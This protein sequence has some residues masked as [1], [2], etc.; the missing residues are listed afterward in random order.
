MKMGEVTTLL[1]ETP[2]PP[3]PEPKLQNYFPANSKTPTQKMFTDGKTSKQPAE[4]LYSSRTGKHENLFNPTPPRARNL[5][6]RGRGRNHSS[7]EVDQ[8]DSP[9][10]REEPPFHHHIIVKTFFLVSIY[11]ILTTIINVTT[12]VI[13]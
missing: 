7:G 10:L 11:L 2:S 5:S 4:D 8:N 13:L 3:L 9:L 12:A 1:P 6:K